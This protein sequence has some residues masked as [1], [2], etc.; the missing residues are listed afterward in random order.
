MPTPPAPP[1]EYR[2]ST[3]REYFESI[4]V[5]VILALF[6]RTFVSLAYQDHGFESAPVLMARV[7]AQRLQLEPD[8]RGPFFER[9]REAAAGVPGV[10]SAAV[11]AIT[12]VSGSMWNTEI[13][14]AG[15]PPL[16]GRDRLSYVN[17]ITPDWLHTFGI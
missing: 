11:S 2:K 4:C 13:Q 1:S 5:A 9:L 14:L 7:N 3:V 15:S 17:L 10:D 6:V 16:S 12:P 8:Q